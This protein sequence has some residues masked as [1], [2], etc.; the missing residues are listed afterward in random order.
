MSIPTVAGSDTSVGKRTS[1]GDGRSITVVQVSFNRVNAGHGAVSLQRRPDEHA[2]SRVEDEISG[3]VITGHNHGMTHD[4]DRADVRIHSQVCGGDVRRGCARSDRRDEVP[5]HQRNHD[6]LVVQHDL[7]RAGHLRVGVQ[8]D[9][10]EDGVRGEHPIG[11]RVGGAP[12]GDIQSHPGRRP[13]PYLHAGRPRGTA[14]RRR[15]HGELLERNRHSHGGPHVGRASGESDVDEGEENEKE[16]EHAA[17]GLAPGKGGGETTENLLQSRAKHEGLKLALCEDMGRIAG[18][19]RSPP[20]RELFVARS[21]LLE[22]AGHAL[23]GVLAVGESRLGCDGH[24]HGLRHGRVIHEPCSTLIEQVGRHEPRIHIPGQPHGVLTVG[25]RGAI[26]LPLGRGTGSEGDVGT[27]RGV[28]HGLAFAS[29]LSDPTNQHRFGRKARDGASLGLRSLSLCTKA[30]RFGGRNG[31][32]QFSSLSSRNRAGRDEIAAAVLG[33]DGDAEGW[34]GDGG[35]IGL[36]RIDEEGEEE[37]E[38]DGH[39]N[40][41]FRA[42]CAGVR[43]IEDGL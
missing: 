37:S 19:T 3:A 24:R 29:R 15:R 10:V 16:I 7:D 6:L 26:G 5:G 34:D 1:V 23:E 38:E 8:V 9:A 12:F 31:F 33:H 27:F 4:S 13:V 2:L 21:T 36:G 20:C 17:S 41:V 35:V 39:G 40:L 22:L 42:V 30:L 32:R 25:D 18:P 11:G 14:T 43:G 28:D